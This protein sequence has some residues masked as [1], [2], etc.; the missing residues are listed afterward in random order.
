MKDH[1]YSNKL[2][3]QLL[4]LGVVYCIT[5]L[6]L[7]YIIFTTPY[8]FG[9]FN[10][11]SLVIGAIAGYFGTYFVQRGGVVNFYLRVHTPTHEEKELD[12]LI[13][14]YRSNIFI[15]VIAIIYAIIAIMMHLPKIYF[16]YEFNL[17][18]VIGMAVLSFL[19]MAGLC[20]GIK[21]VSAWWNIKRNW[22][23][24]FGS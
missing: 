6:V 3:G 17:N 9:F 23:K 14:Q 18:N 12:T 7:S 24:E 15:T 11:L 16:N 20:N 4:G 22:K 1:K 5:G 2:L 13:S 19:S 10:T 21:F 8:Y